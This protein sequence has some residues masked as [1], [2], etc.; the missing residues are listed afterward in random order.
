MS[1]Y[2]NSCQCGFGCPYNCVN[3]GSGN[4]GY[5]S[6]MGIQKPI[7][8]YHPVYGSTMCNKNI[9]WVERKRTHPPLFYPPNPYFY[10]PNKN[11]NLYDPNLPR[12]S[13]DLGFYTY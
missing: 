11:G 7:E 3:S 12:Q 9:S 10:I 2:Q 4:I 8:R 13:I 5:M 6:S 1:L